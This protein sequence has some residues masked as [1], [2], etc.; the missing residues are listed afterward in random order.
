MEA[1]DH[2][3]KRKSGSFVRSKIQE[4]SKKI[5]MKIIK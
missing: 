1:M 4:Y 2:E 3:I 5:V